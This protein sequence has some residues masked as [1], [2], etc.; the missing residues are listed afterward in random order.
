[1]TIKKK[2]IFKKI[3]ALI[4]CGLVLLTTVMQ[5]FAVSEEKYVPEVPADEYG[6][7]FT[8]FDETMTPGENGTYNATMTARM[9]GNSD[10]TTGIQGG[11]VQWFW[12]SNLPTPTLSNT[13]ELGAFNPVTEDAEKN[14]K[15]QRVVFRYYRDSDHGAYI[16]GE[17]RTGYK[18]FNL[19]FANVNAI[20]GQAFDVIVQD[21]YS[22]SLG[23][24]TLLLYP[25][26]GEEEVPLVRGNVTGGQLRAPGRTITYKSN[27]EGTETYIQQYMTDEELT[28]KRILSLEEVGFTPVEDKN[29]LGWSIYSDS[30]N[31]IQYR[32]G[33]SLEEKDANG[34]YKIQNVTLYPVYQ[35]D[36]HL[37]GNWVDYIVYDTVA[38]T[39]PTLAKGR[40]NATLNA[41]LL[42]DMAKHVEIT[43]SVLEWSWPSRLPAPELQNMPESTDDIIPDYQLPEDD[44]LDLI[45]HRR[46]YKWYRNPDHG[47]LTPTNDGTGYGYH[48]FQMYFYNFAAEP[49]EVIKNIRLRDNF[50]KE[51]EISMTNG[52]SPT[53]EETITERC[54]VIT[55]SITIPG[56]KIIY[57]A[58]NSENSKTY[59]QVYYSDAEMADAT[60]LEND[61]TQNPNQ[62]LTKPNFD[63]PAGKE[64]GGW[65]VEV[66]A[67]EA[68]YQPGEALTELKNMTLY[69]V[70]V[71]KNSYTV[72]YNGNGGTPEK[73]FDEVLIGDALGELP[74]ATHPEGY[75]FLGWYTKAEGGNKVQA[76][77]TPV[78]NTELYAHWETTYK[79]SYLA[80]NGSG[81]VKDESSPYRKDAYVIVKK[82]D[83]LNSP[84]EGWIF[85]GWESNLAVTVGSSQKTILNPDDIFRMPEQDITLTALW[86]NTIS[87]VC[88]IVLDLTEES[89]KNK[90][91]EDI[92]TGF[93]ASRSVIAVTGDAFKGCNANHTHELI[94]KGTTTKEVSIEGNKT[95]EFN[96]FVNGVQ[97]KILNLDSNGTVTFGSDGATM[98][99]LFN[100]M[101]GEGLIFGNDVHEVKINDGVT[102]LSVSAAKEKN[103]VTGTDGKVKVLDLTM[104]EVSEADKQLVVNG[105]DILLPSNYL[106]IVMLDN[107]EGT[108]LQGKIQVTDT[109]GNEY[110]RGIAENSEDTEYIDS[111]YSDQ[112]IY[113]N[114][115]DLT[116][117]GI[118]PSDAGE[119]GMYGE[120]HIP[121]KVNQLKVTVPTRIVF[122]IYTDGINEANHGF[123]A[124][125]VKLTNESETFM[126]SIKL[127]TSSGLI[128]KNYGGENHKANVGYMGIIEDG[129]SSY[130]LESYADMTVEQMN[131]SVT[132]P[133]VCIEAEAKID[134]NPRIKLKQEVDYSTV[135][136]FWFAAKRGDTALQLKVPSDYENGSNTK[137]YYQIPK[138]VINDR[139]GNTIL[140]G[141]HK[142]RLSFAMGDAE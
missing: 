13:P 34:R 134:S 96:V 137:R 56:R 94:I 43:G 44:G 116:G 130:T 50:H 92:D 24:S 51:Q 70:W 89:L 28:G 35:G 112:N 99:N 121:V 64:F 135:P 68:M 72:T 10:T 40:Y 75:I 102:V 21:Y 37:D 122:N 5:V 16:Q 66:N 30:I 128:V 91:G 125:T 18:T 55:G 57:K 110:V 41:R 27:A 79:V 49:G 48:E 107:N 58:D 138:D 15:E 124:P 106:R 98:T 101:S 29:F 7:D 127:Q 83:G 111:N 81:E 67:A 14:M 109:D 114:T 104:H 2:S 38:D 45:T 65:S 74:S 133:V 4:L 12:S 73:D 132:K 126:D 9:T 8:V 100:S 33:M 46:G 141:Y 23:E 59:E 11:A 97:A 115:F 36:E 86:D 47:A 52:T 131:Q 82:P 25:S 88:P 3:S 105:K 22:P 78:E 53:G 140:Y 63:A 77:F 69:P 6:M 139:D 136:V 118:T 1:M 26:N 31:Q 17:N 80:G 20:P 84:G 108:W 95:K 85:A 119:K 42:T 39:D 117:T 32:P 90:K 93:V 19:N 71:A 120:V 113:G 61:P 54:H 129:V 60:I 103:P 142:M 76:P 62:P 87:D 123:I